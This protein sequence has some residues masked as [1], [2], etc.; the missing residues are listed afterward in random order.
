MKNYYV[1]SILLILFTIHSSA[2][3]WEW[4]KNIDLGVVE[5]GVSIGVDKIGNAYVAGYANQA[6]SGGVPATY[7][8][9]F[10][11]F[12]SAGNQF[13]FKEIWVWESVTDYIGNTYLI[14][15][16]GEIGKY[17]KDGT[18]LWVKRV[19]NAIF[20]KISLVPNGGVVVSGRN[21]QN[22]G[23]QFECSTL[24]GD[25]RFFRAR[26]DD[27]GTCLW[28]IESDTFAACSITVGK[29]NKIYA[30]GSGIS[31]NEGNKTWIEIYELDNGSL[32]K[33]I[34]TNSVYY[35]KN[36]CI[37]SFNN[38]IVSDQLSSNQPLNINGT[39]YNGEGI[40]LVKYSTEGNLMFVKII[41]GRKLYSPKIGT[42]TLNNIYLSGEYEE[43]FFDQISL[44][45]PQRELFVLKM[46]RDGNAIWIK[47]SNNTGERGSIFPNNMVVSSKGDVFITGSISGKYSFDTVTLDATNN[48]PYP[49]MFIGKISG[50]YDEP[51]TIN[52]YEEQGNLLYIYPNPTRDHLIIDYQAE[53]TSS[54]NL[55]IRNLAGVVIYEAPVQNPSGTF[56]KEIDIGKHAP[57]LYFVEL[58]TDKD[59]L[60]QKIVVKR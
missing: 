22:N 18:E 44:E 35:P 8:S 13:W 53:Y 3:N 36:I 59:R 4:V 54:I 2:Q 16:N 39:F 9:I 23:S 31:D 37:D 43:L 49:D 48:S 27:N 10:Y 26:F 12:D 34:K 58:I 6:Y 25:N 11:K 40:Y 42:D 17:D 60:V 33:E 29:N 14:R 19:P 1:L 51:T 50:G 57:G 21:F 38:I 46:G 55:Q 30:S 15:G 56:Q 32:F 41:K 7:S 24:T 45:S 47:S 28:A 52:V 20:E 5:R